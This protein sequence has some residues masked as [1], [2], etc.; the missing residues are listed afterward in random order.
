[1]KIGLCKGRH[2]IPEVEGYVFPHEI[3]DPT[4]LDMMEQR[5]HESI[6]HLYGTEEELELYVTGLS[7]ALVTV[8][9]YCTMGRIKLSLYHYDKVTGNYYRQ[10]VYNWFDELREGG[11]L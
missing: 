7:V 2:E 3:S 1:M 6:K 11:Y 10:P 8:I 5:V 4:R 9:N